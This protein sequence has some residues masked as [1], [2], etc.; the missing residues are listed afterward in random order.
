MACVR[1]NPLQKM[2]M[3]PVAETATVTLLAIV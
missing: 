2:L 1:P 3:A